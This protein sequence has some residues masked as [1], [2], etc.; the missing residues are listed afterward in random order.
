M[1]V[2]PP[3]SIEDLPALPDDTSEIEQVAARDD[4][5]TVLPRSFGDADAGRFVNGYF[6]VSGLEI[7]IFARTQDDGVTGDFSF[8]E[9]AELDQRP[10]KVGELWNQ[11]LIFEDPD[12]VTVEWLRERLNYETCWLSTGEAPAEPFHE[13][14]EEPYSHE[15]AGMPEC[16]HTALTSPFKPPKLDIRVICCEACEMPIAFE[17]DDGE[18]VKYDEIVSTDF[19]GLPSPR[20]ND[21]TRGV[22]VSPHGELTN[23]EVTLHFLSRVAML[24]T[25]S[26]DLYVRDEQNGY[27]LCFGNAVVGYAMWS[28]VGD[29]VALQQ[30]YILPPFRGNRL[31]TVLLEAWYDYI[32]AE[33]YYTI[34]SNEVARRS[35]RAAGHLD[36]GIAKPG[37]ML[38]SGDSVDPADF[39]PGYVDRLRRGMA[40]GGVDRRFVADE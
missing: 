6:T 38:G 25:G 1:S 34:R 3:V 5:W 30:R 17:M 21:H 23:P 11:S 36:A 7:S 15:A 35:L 40:S 16:D 13:W 14:A 24:E 10:V 32:D 39:S 31:G 29:Y 22:A 26:L 37:T 20:S 8:I 33:T 27:L 12:G 9:S 28:E 18:I 4:V 2:S 19:I